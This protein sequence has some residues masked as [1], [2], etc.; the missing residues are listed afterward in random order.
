MV[1][2]RHV[3]RGPPRPAECCLNRIER[4]SRKR[5]KGSPETDGYCAYFAVRIGCQRSF[6]LR[7]GKAVGEAFAIEA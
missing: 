7:S 4:S 2:P 5:D 6:V 1:G 3:L